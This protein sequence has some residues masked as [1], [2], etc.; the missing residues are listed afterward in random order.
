VRRFLTFAVLFSSCLATGLPPAFAESCVPVGRWVEPA[1]K[2][3]GNPSGEPVAIDNPALIA[4]AARSPVVL[5]GEHH[6]DTDH[7]RWQLQT[8]AGLLAYRSDL[9]IG[10]EMLPRR[11]QPALDRWVAGQTSEAE[12]LKESNW[13]SVWGFDP[14]LYLP[15][16]HFARMH[17]LPMVALNVDRELVAA[18]G[19]GGWSAV[20]A[21][22]REGVGDPAPAP[23]A[24]LDRLG[25]TYSAH[26][27]GNS[28]RP[29]PDDPNFRRFTDAQLLWDRAMAEALAG[30]RRST[31]ALAVGIIGAGHLEWRHGVP[32]QLAALGIPDSL[33]L[34]PW[35]GNQPCQELS[36]GVADAVFGMA[37]TAADERPSWRPRL[38]VSLASAEDGVRIE[39]V[40]GDSVAAA[41]GLQAGDIILTAA[42]TDTREVRELMDI[43]RRQAPGTWLPLSIRRAGSTQEVIAKFPTL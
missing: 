33:V 11:A 2:P 30:A 21:E 12:F 8:L 31:G 17:R 15:I 19:R 20:P 10:L 36:R 43:V 13:R 1:A 22:K 40:V 39:S 34:M 29:A 41:A 23:T 35:N 7:H 9:V 26:D 24:Y 14:A 5:L 27:R 25:E 42:G 38:G 3:A 18:V 16:L 37:A 32:H 6:D 28:A 4:R